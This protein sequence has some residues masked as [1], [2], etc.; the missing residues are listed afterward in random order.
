MDYTRHRQTA[1]RLID[2]FG[3]PA[4]I[5]LK[6]RAGV[7]LNAEYQTR[8]VPTKAVIF[9]DDGVT[10]VN[11]NITGSPSIVLCAPVLTGGLNEINVGDT[12]SVGIRTLT[13][14][15]IKPL[16]PDQTGAILWTLLA[17]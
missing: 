1:Q 4:V 13:V 3:A 10:F 14:K 16:D 2:K 7:G 9:P 17:V 15:L 11:H 5:T 8:D 6:R 12:V